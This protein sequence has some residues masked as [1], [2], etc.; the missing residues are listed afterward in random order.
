MAHLAAC[1]ESFDLFKVNDGS[2]GYGESQNIS[3]ERAAVDDDNDD[4]DLATHHGRGH[5]PRHAD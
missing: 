1:S 4:K 3:S 5:V 2:R